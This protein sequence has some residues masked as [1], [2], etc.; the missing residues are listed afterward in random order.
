MQLMTL[1]RR[2][3]KATSIALSAVF[4]W[5]TGVAC[6]VACSSVSPF[7]AS[8]VEKPLERHS[9][10][11]GESC[12]MPRSPASNEGGARV[13]T[14]GVAACSLLAGYGVGEAPRTVS[15][16]SAVASEPELAIFSRESLGHVAR[17]EPATRLPDRHETYLRCCVFLI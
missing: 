10:C 9:C 13:S 16:Q 4:V 12:E 3:R 15:A 7:V 11:S 1:T 14:D 5:L 8:V 6:L 17:V 2:Q